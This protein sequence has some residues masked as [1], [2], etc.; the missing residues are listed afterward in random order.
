MKLLASLTSP[1]VRKV[2]IVLAEKKIEYDLEQENP[3]SSDTKV[4]QYNPLGKVPA[5]ELDDGSTLYD[6]RV[7]VDYLDT[8]TP[9]SRLMPDTTRQ[10]IMV[11]RW[12]AL[13]DGVSEAAATIFLERKRSKSQQSPDWIRRQY[14]KIHAGLKAM[15]E[16]L[17]EKGFCTGESY[18][19]ADIA[20]GCTLFY[21]DF[22]FPDVSW[23]EPYANLGKLAE[24]LAKRQSFIDTA[25]P[26]S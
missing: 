14:D 12:E 2:R 15:S 7:I 24:K 25:P 19:L 1:F 11:K 3:W 5:L 23:R 17:G 22:R 16:D 10:R 13:A 6:S 4:S 9:V 18:N 8:V 21:L 26:Q 20:T